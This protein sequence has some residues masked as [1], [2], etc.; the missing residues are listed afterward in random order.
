MS[1]KCINALSSP[2]QLLIWILFYPLSSIAKRKN[3]P[4]HLD[5][6]CLRATILELVIN[7]F[8]YTLPANWPTISVLLPIRAAILSICS[9][10]R[11]LAKASAGVILAQFIPAAQNA[12]GHVCNPVPVQIKMN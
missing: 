12:P 2:Y 10:F 6:S 4:T 11:G 1:S 5:F 7:F 9:Y 8:L 3:Y